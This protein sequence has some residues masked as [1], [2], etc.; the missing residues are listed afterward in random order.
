[1][2]KYKY[3]IRH[4]SSYL[5]FLPG[6]AFY[7][8]SPFFFSPCS[9]VAG[10]YIMVSIAMLQFAFSRSSSPISNSVN[11]LESWLLACLLM[12]FLLLLEILITLKYRARCKN[13]QQISQSSNRSTANHKQAKVST[14]S[15]SKTN[16]VEHLITVEDLQQV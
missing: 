14:S 9:V 1:M 11:A 2:I 5:K 6:L 12:I 4:P 7:L 10:A 3:Y 8:G 16:I 13:K 15:Q